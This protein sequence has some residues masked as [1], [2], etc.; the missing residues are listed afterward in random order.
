[1]E[2]QISVWLEFAQKEA[3]IRVK[4]KKKI[5]QGAVDQKKKKKIKSNFFNFPNWPK[6]YCFMKKKKMP[7]AAIL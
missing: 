3:C 1:M 7:F 6:L 2:W 4:K 5:K